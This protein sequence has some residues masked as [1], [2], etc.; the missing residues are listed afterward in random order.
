MVSDFLV[1]RSDLGSDHN[2]VME[3]RVVREVDGKLVAN[4][5]EN[6]VA[7][8]QRLA[9]TNTLTRQRDQ[10]IKAYLKYALGYAT[11]GYTLGPWFRTTTQSDLEFAVAGRE[12]IAGRDAIVVAYIL[13]WVN[14]TIVV[15]RQIT[16][17]V[18][19]ARTE[20]DY[21]PSAFGVWTPR[22]IVASIFRKAEDKKAP[23]TYEEARIT[24]TYEPFKR[25]EVTTQTDIQAPR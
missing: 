23:V 5:T 17:P 14:E 11:F 16:T 2:D 24:F 13:H 25:F 3:F 4:S 7:L 8:F 6:A 9:K 21:E 22:K 20:I 10:L 12:R 15:D 1:Y 19:F 18:T